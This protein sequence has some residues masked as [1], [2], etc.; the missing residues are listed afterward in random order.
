MDNLAERV[1]NFWYRSVTQHPS[2]LVDRSHSH[3]CLNNAQGI[4]NG[5]ASNA[6]TIDGKCAKAIEVNGGIDITIFEVAIR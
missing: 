1:S 2:D 6:E 3:R 4:C 5:R